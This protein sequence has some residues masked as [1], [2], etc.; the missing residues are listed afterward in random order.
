MKTHK[1]KL[2][3]FFFI[4]MSFAFTQCKD[5]KDTVVTKLLEAEAE[6]VN[7]Q[8]P[9]QLDEVTRL[10]SCRVEGKMRLVTYVTVSY[11]DGKMFDLEDY[12]R[13]VK[14]SLVYA[15]QTNKEVDLVKKAGV[16]FVY[17]YRDNSGKL[18]GN[19]EITP[20]DYNQQINEDN[21]ELLSSMGEDDLTLL[22]ESTAAGIQQAL[23]IAIDEITT[24]QNCSFVS[25]KTLSYEY[26]LAMKKSDIDT[27]FTSNMKRELIKGIGDDENI[28]NMLNAGVIFS[29]KYS[30]ET[31]VD[32]CTIE[33][34]KDDF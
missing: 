33:V 18:F 31:G 14:P 23:P 29:Y 8:C 24:L 7:A 26:I 1:Q 28:M 20:D 30:D 4:F 11:V 9:I 34:T 13:M 27:D 5:A 10:D 12:A 15:I 17:L 6:K 2:A 21:K 32:I 19:I 22:L 16:V 25:P 3:I